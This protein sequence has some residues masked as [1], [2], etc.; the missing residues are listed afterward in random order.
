LSVHRYPQPS[1]RSRRLWRFHGGVHLPD[2]KALSNT[3]PP[4]RAELPGRLILPL[5]Q[6]IG[7][8]AEP[9]VKAGDRVLKGQ[10]IGRPRSYVSAALHAPTSGRVTA[11]EDHPVPHPSGLSA[12]C[13]LIE[14]DG[15]ERW[16][17]L[18]EPMPDF[19][20]RDP[21]EIRERIRWA[22]IV[23]LGG[24]A[25]PA[26][27]KLNPG[28]PIHT[29][30]LNGAECEPYITCDDLLM[31]GRPE[32]ILEGIPILLHLTGA[33]RCLIG[34]EDNKP[35]AIRALYEAARGDERIE[36]VR[37]PTLYPSGGEKQLIYVLTGKEVPSNG[38][39][40]DIGM[41]C[42]NVGTAAAIADAVLRGRPLISRLV[43]VTGGGVAQ[44]GNFEALIGTPVA[45]LIRQAGGYTGRGDR[46]VLGGPMMGFALSD[47]GIPLHKAG[48]CLLLPT[49]E[50]APDP[51][52]A[53]ACIRCGRC[54]EACPV[55]LL[56]QQLYWFARAK[57]LDRVQ[58][59]NLFDCI[60]CACCA[61]VCP[62]HIPLVQYY[63]YA[64][65][66][67]WERE[68]E[69]RQAE[70]ARRRHEARQA[71]LERLERERQ[72]RLR[73]KKAALAKPPAKGDDPRKAAIEAAKRRAAEKRAALAAQGKTPRN[74]ENLTPA[75][76]RQVEA[77]EA[78]RAAAAGSDTQE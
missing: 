24:A 12:P 51:G 15:E 46:L 71:R 77:A 27:V 2:R 17:E 29:L 69:R 26:S 41:V 34:I 67:I 53:L 55:N 73:K 6:H 13:I 16:A 33:E 70:H 44:P 8:A 28:R 36:V 19:G 43:T 14:P 74:T 23:G 76:R 35:E 31:R 54:A 56:P 1:G 9:L 60:E 68:R 75:Q 39:P 57:D 37:I 66:E 62:S 5:Q 11:I 32:A 42:H 72:A 30:I 64:K 10:L 20:T 18:P 38:L 52:S 78:R 50:E 48:N 47:D 25:F 63:R 59:F 61:Q 45:D 65:T 40:A 49:P 58:D 7:E 3:R 22:G 21:A 4:L